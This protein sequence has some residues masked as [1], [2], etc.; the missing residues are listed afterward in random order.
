MSSDGES[1]NIRKPV[2]KI[3][4]SNNFLDDKGEFN[5]G[6]LGKDNSSEFVSDTEDIAAPSQSNQDAMKASIDIDT[7]LKLPL[8]TGKILQKRKC[9]TVA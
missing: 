8:H 3:L 9:Y 4:T 1:Q 2:H 6:A 5:M 7:P